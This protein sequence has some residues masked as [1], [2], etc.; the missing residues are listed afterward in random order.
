MSLLSGVD[1][2][3]SLNELS[4]GT[5]ISGKTLNRFLNYEDFSDVVNQINLK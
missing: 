5:G 1:N 4:V 2:I 3:N